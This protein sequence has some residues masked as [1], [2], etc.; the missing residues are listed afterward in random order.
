MLKAALILFFT[1]GLAGS[2]SFAESEEENSPNPYA[3]PT[4]QSFRA[5]RSPTL[6]NLDYAVRN[7]E[8]MPYPYRVARPYLALMWLTTVSTS[9]VA[10]F[11]FGTHLQPGPGATPAQLVMAGTGVAAIFVAVAAGTATVYWLTTLPLLD[12][13]FARPI[14]EW[15]EGAIDTY[16]RAAA[17]F[18]AEAQPLPAPLHNRM[19]NIDAVY[20]TNCAEDLAHLRLR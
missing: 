13:A 7:M 12:R 20:G 14:A 2:P 16:E 19:K 8:G 9:M 3:A 4:S 11:H 5:P 10:T 17:K 18:L 6:L 1:V 15:R